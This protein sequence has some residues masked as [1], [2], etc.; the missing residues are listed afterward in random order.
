MRIKGFI[1]NTF[2]EYPG[3]IASIIFLQGCNFRCPFCFNPEMIPET[4]GEVSEDEVFD[5]L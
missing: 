2:I 1:K 5:F 3:K 4:A